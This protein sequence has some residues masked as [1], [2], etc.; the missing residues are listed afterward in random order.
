MALALIRRILCCFRHPQR[1]ADNE[2]AAPAPGGAFALGAEAFA[3]VTLVQKVGR[4]P[5]VVRHSHGYALLPQ[6]REPWSG[7]RP[8]AARSTNRCRTAGMR[9]APPPAVPCQCRPGGSWH[10][11]P[12]RRRARATRVY[13]QRRLLQ[14]SR[15]RPPAARPPATPT[16][17]RARNSTLDRVP[18]CILLA[19][20][21]LAFIILEGRQG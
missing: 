6:L 17:P 14:P 8:A 11:Q 9:A 4:R 1:D 21:I 12:S 15:S 13:T 18:R 16:F 10:P 5:K 7:G 3:T 19:S 2:A 20:I